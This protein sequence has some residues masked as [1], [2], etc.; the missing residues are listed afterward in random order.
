VGAEAIN[1]H[2]VL[3]S[4]EFVA[5]AHARGLAVFVY[6]VDDE[7]LMTELLDR[8]VDGLFTNFPARMRA[9]VDS[10]DGRARWGGGA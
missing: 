10:P 2:F 8:G 1:P 3:A 6:T 4:P 9:L 7:T 5:E